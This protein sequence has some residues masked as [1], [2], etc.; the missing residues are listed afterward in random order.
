MVPG[1]R[2]EDDVSVSGA[3]LAGMLGLDT[4]DEAVE[5]I[6]E[7]ETSRAPCIHCEGEPRW[8][9]GSRVHRA[10]CVVRLPRAVW[11]DRVGAAIAG[12]ARPE[13]QR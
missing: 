5:H 6:A 10:G 2:G 8:F 12:M 11:R 3:Q 7:V 9:D 13:R 1:V 4:E